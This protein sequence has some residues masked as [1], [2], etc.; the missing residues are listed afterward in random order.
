MPGHQPV[1]SSHLSQ[2][3]GTVD[4]QGKLSDN[5]SFIFNH[6]QRSNPYRIRSY[7]AAV[8]YSASG[9]LFN[10]LIVVYFWGI[11]YFVALSLLLVE[12]PVEDG[13]FYPHWKA[14]HRLENV[15]PPW[16]GDF[17]QKCVIAFCLSWIIQRS[18]NKGMFV[19]CSVTKARMIVNWQS[20]HCVSVGNWPLCLNL[21]K[22]FGIKQCKLPVIVR[23]LVITRL[24]P[25]IFKPSPLNPFLCTAL[26][27]CGFP[28]GRKENR[29]LTGGTES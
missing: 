2:V 1:I 7:V 19:L 21:T 20:V 28:V 22:P 29:P 5:T 23:A 12:D 16:W 8:H 14:T 18:V 11:F 27:F 10:S 13:S 24:L 17:D 6:V 26:C 3:E 15:S 9:A 4:F 25:H